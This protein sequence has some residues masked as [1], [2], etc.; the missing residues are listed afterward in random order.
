MRLVA[1]PHPFKTATV[2]YTV[3]HGLTLAE[4]V[5]TLGLDPVLVAHA[6]VFINDQLIP[7]ENWR[8][9]R[10]NAHTTISLRVSPMGGGGGDGGKNP[11]RT[12]FT[13]AIIAASF[14]FGPV[15]GSILAPGGIT[16][17]ASTIAAAS[18]GRAV[19]M[20]AGVLLQNVIAP[21]RP[22][23]LAG[24]SGTSTQR[25]SPTLFIE[26]ARNS[27][28]PFGT[29]PVV[30]GTHRMYPPL[31][32]APYTEIVGEDQFLRMVVVWGYGP[33]LVEDIKIGETPIANFDD[34]EIETLEGRVG[35]PALTLFSNNVQQDDYTILLTQA[36]DWQ[37]RTAP[38][39][40]DELSVDVVWP[41]GLV[42]FNTSG[43]RLALSVAFQIQYRPTSGGSWLTPTFTA[44][45]LDPTT[46]DNW[47][48]GDTVTVT[49]NRTAAIRHGFTW[50]PA[51][52]RGDYEVRIRRTSADTDD[53]QIFDKFTW[54]ALRGITAD[55]PLNFGLPVAATAL[56]IKASGQLNRIVD[57]LNGIVSSYVDT[58]SGS[59]TWGEGVTSNPAALFRHVLQGPANAAALDDARVD[60]DRLQDWF[61]FCVTNGFEFNMVRDFQASVWN[62]LADIASAGRASPT[63]IDGKWSVIYDE[64]QTIP[65]QHFTPR[66]SWGFEA[67]KGFPNQPHAFRVRFNN[68]DEDWR[69]DERIV[70]ADGYT[71]ANATDF[72][73]LDAPGMTD[74]NHV[75]K[76]T[77][78]QIAQAL[79]RPERWSFNVD[80]E[81]LIAQRG[82]LVL[83]T[84]DVLLVGLASGRITA[85]QV[86]GS[87]NM[88]GFTS[89][90][91]LTMTG[92]TDYGVSIRTLDDAELTGQIV[93]NAGDQTT[94]VMTTPV[95]V[96]D[97]P[98][99]GDLFGFGA[100]GSETVE[101]LVL[102]IEP[103]GDLS[104]RIVCIPNSPA[105][106]TADTGTI[107]AFVTGLTPVPQVPTAVIVSARS[108]ES[109]LQLG[110][111]NTLLS[112]V[113]L[114][115]APTNYRGAVL[116]IQMRATSTGEP[117]YDANV[118]S[119]QGREHIVSDVEQGRY[120]DFR[121]R[122]FDSNLLKAGGD[123][124]YLNG[125]RVVGQTN[126]PAALV[127]ATI[128]AFGG[129]ALIR[130]DTPNEL[131][132]RFGGVVKFRHSPQTIAANATWAAST[133]IGTA[134]KG[135]ALIAQ[136]PLKP[137]TYLARVFDKSGRPGGIIALAT[138]QASV[139]LFANVD[140]V[141]EG[142]IFTGVKS[143]VVLDGSTLKL[144][145]AGSFDAIPD[146]DAMTVDL[147]YYGGN[148]VSGT[149]TFTS[150]LDLGSVSRVRLTSVITATSVNTAD[151]IDDRTDN[152]DTWESF[153]GDVQAVA[154]CRISVRHTDD[155]PAGS[156]VSWS[157]WNTL[158]SAEFDA[159]GFQFRATLSTADPAFN[160]FVTAL[161]VVVEDI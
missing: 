113:G 132:V 90:E 146:L 47:I 20:V 144:A 158:D 36:D 16:F 89:D 23:S 130:W 119:V 24:L 117:F 159:R 1:A 96:A 122:W 72:E 52:G 127:N 111:G 75:W 60:I 35:D 13:I 50:T 134:A 38:A 123:W 66:N 110:S 149:Y 118:S 108:D 79:L 32:A 12:I 131:D 68:R 11:L 65:V 143:N 97:V 106:Y 104:A 83:V 139:L 64:L 58:Y 129:S 37:T 92:G 121:V 150:G 6:H 156:P 91:V 76:F 42:K 61:T 141:T 85:I 17:G 142:P 27:A 4:V 133:S 98:V 124:T 63:V 78:F 140:T 10:P 55:D 87:G 7:R 154:D 3:E 103:S 14:Y 81:Y 46:K 125:H 62:T 155:D 71:S 153:D 15:V 5:D 31:G 26:G 9:V 21:I 45:T 41:Q 138:K 128:S 30:L 99:V 2:D 19:V 28:R 93:T 25:D 82:D 147:D 29:I 8:L 161:G 70:Y 115:I 152:I 86:D 34:V 120:Y 148:E 105:V 44:T 116:H 80:F 145:G 73:G 114:T 56:R 69:N 137:G 107:P 57:E 94:V 126:P 157:A 84:H 18:L 33:L 160:I 40:R 51:A 77:R 59:P 54:A 101:G 49:H 48:S 53:T 102:S 135:D 39:I 74:S 43:A 112:R 109:I 88:T 151:L 136:L 100:L 95:P 22:P 67:E